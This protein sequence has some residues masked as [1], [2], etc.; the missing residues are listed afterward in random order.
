[1]PSDKFFVIESWWFKAVVTFSP[2]EFDPSGCDGLYVH[3]VR[4]T[5]LGYLYGY[6]SIIWSRILEIFRK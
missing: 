2:T 4:I 3:S 6:Y 1:M 5:P